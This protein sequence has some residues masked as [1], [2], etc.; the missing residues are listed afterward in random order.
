[1]I[2]TNW[3]KAECCLN[4]FMNSQDAGLES[5]GSKKR[6]SSKFDIVSRYPNKFLV[7]STI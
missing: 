1:M 4:N 6:D 3:M 5:T 7:T 2:Y